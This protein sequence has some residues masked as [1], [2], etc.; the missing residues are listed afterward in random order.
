[1][2]VPFGIS[3]GWF[4]NQASHVEGIILF[5]TTDV[6]SPWNPNLFDRSTQPKKEWEVISSKPKWYGIIFLNWTLLLKAYH[7]RTCI[8]N[9]THTCA[10]SVVLFQAMPVMLNESCYSLFFGSLKYFYWSLLSFSFHRT[11][12]RVMVRY[13]NIHRL[14]LLVHSTITFILNYFFLFFFYKRGV[15]QITSNPN[16]NNGIV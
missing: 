16:E 3:S 10:L 6:C 11:R 8:F 12:L 1:M 13:C 14:L 15:Q 4:S 7:K 2:Y 5:G 9:F